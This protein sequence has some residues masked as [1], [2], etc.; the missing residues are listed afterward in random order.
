MKV[1]WTVIY[2]SIVTDIIRYSKTFS[3]LHHIASQKLNF[4]LI[5]WG[6]IS[7]RPPSDLVLCMILDPNKATGIDNIGPKI[8]KYCAFALTRPL[9]H[10]FNLSLASGVIP[11]EWKVHIVVPVYKSG[12]RSSV[13]NYRPISL[14]CNTS[15]ILE[16]LVY[17]RIINFVLNNI[18]N[19]Q[20]GFL[21]GRSTTQQ[22]LLCLH[23]IYK[24]TSE[25][26]Q[27]DSI[28]LDFRKAFDSVS[29]NKLLI[30]LAFYGI[31]GSFWNWFNCYPNN[32]SQS[33]KICNAISNPLPV[34]SG[35]PQGSILGPLLFWSTLMIYHWM[36][37]QFCNI[38]LF[39][40]EQNNSSPNRS[41]RFTAGSRSTLYLEYTL[42]LQYRLGV[43]L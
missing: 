7:P 32:R 24:A 18:T 13:K 29:H 38:F 39:A 20:F 40:D 11:Q 37:T 21:P 5:S 17:S 30:K 12:D 4:F 1:N 10:L 19:C 8:L 3:K 6:S 16:S 26:H 36:I 14:L 33:V 31:T 15:K 25:G 41:L 23:T 35:V 43:T 28:Y 9:C 27:T 22:L 34:L 2:P 42:Y